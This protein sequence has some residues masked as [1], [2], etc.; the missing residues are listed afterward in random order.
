M[1][2]ILIVAWILLALVH[3]MPAAVLARP[4]LITSLYGVE[5]AG[6]LGVLLIHRGSLFLA[7]VLVCLYAA[8]EPGARRAASLVVAISVVSFL[9]IYVSAGAPSGSLR[10]IALADFIA[11]APLGLVAWQAWRN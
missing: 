8:W 5:A 10:L 2:M 7:I 9:A 1:A 3:V 6:D 11:L 4:G